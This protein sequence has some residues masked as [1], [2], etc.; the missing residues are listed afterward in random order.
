MY[1][2]RCNGCGNETDVIRGFGNC[3]DCIIDDHNANAA[4]IKVAAVAKRNARAA[5]KRRHVN[6]GC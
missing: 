3:A 1:N 4:A 6:G 5:N 2:G